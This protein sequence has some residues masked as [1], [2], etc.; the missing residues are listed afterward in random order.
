MLD[1]V[2]LVLRETLEAALFISLLLALGGHLGLRGRWAWVAMPLGLLASWV[3]S[4]A[5]G[6]IADAFDGTGQELLNAA[7]YATAIGCFIVLNTLLVPLLARGAPMAQPPRVHATTFR[8]LFVAIVSCSI[9]RE[10]SE[11]W[12]YLS[13]FS[14]VPDAMAA[15]VAG[16]LIGTGIGL[17]LCA[18]IYYTFSFLGRGTFLRLF[19]GLVTL[20]VGGLSMQLARQGLQIGW[21]DSGTALWDTTWLVSERSWLG[22][23][24]HALFGYDANPD[25]TQVLFYAG[26]LLAV[27]VGVT[28]QVWRRRPVHA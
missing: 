4:R 5:A 7:L 20:V 28:V 13:S 16:G 15:A 26:S 9:A 1:A 24:L 2:M 11:V 17:S 27:V 25:A 23:L 14:G 8:V 22:E 18:L 19:F 3:L 12:I 21:L 10:G 6:S